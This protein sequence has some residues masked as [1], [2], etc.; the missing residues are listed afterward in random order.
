MRRATYSPSQ[1]LITAAVLM[2]CWVIFF[3]S[4][5][6]L[7]RIAKELFCVGFGC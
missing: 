1:W 2:A 6:F 4:I 7:S 5:G 3:V